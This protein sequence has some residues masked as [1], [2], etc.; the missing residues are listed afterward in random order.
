MALGPEKEAKH[1]MDAIRTN[2]DWVLS[3]EKKSAAGRLAALFFREMTYLLVMGG[4]PWAAAAACF[5]S[6][7][8][9][10]GSGVTPLKPSSLRSSASSFA[11]ISLFSFRNCLAFSRPW[12][13]R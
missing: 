6:G 8:G 11:V 3:L 5:C 13:M 2:P 12:P 7:V 4:L 9:E 10:G 1:D